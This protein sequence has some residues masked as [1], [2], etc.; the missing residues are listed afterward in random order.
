LKTLQYPVAS[1]VG[2]GTMLR[3]NGTNE[4]TFTVDSI[5]TD[6]LSFSL[7]PNFTNQTIT[8]QKIIGLE[9]LANNYRIVTD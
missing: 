8:G 9:E 4:V 5:G 2:V 1:D 7:T 3:L 6:G